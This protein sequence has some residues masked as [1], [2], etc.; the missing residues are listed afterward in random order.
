[1]EILFE[2]FFFAAKTIMNGSSY[3]HGE[4]EKAVLDSA[5]K[6]LEIEGMVGI[7]MRRIAKEIGV[8]HQAPYKHFASRDEILLELRAR[9]F[10][11]LTKG[12]GEARSNHPR[13]IRLQLQ[14]VGVMY[15]SNAMQF[16]RMYDL[17]FGGIVNQKI[18]SLNHRVCAD[19][20][21]HALASIIHGDTAPFSKQSLERARI[22]WS[23]MH[24]I[25]DLSLSGYLLQP[26]WIA[27]DA[28][29]LAVESLAASWFDVR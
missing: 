26:E 14:A 29:K 3:H 21:F 24:G 28:V 2:L 22:F 8:S 13:S 27:E 4:L 20:S 25:A 7:S 16:P 6:M 9:G 1:L 12:I 18:A 10:Q 15:V 19:Q 5:E 11:R 23:C 17:M